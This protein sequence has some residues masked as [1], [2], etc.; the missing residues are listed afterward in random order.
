MKKF[1]YF[2]ILF[3][4]IPSF[5]F[6]NSVS[7]SSSNKDGVYEKLDDEIIFAGKTFRNEIT[8]EYFTFFKDGSFEGMTNQQ[9]IQD[10]KWELKK[11]KGAWESTYR[12][13]TEFSFGS[14]SLTIYSGNLK[15]RY[16]VDR[17]EPDYFWFQ[18]DERN[19][20]NLCFDTLM[21]LF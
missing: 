16:W 10:K 3:I 8:E 2:I 14:N 21:K 13:A 9:R 7:F 1:R 20:D 6:S 18:L 12:E 19:F 17:K 4:L 5:C 11:L 15:C